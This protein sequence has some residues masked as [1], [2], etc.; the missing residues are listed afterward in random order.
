MQTLN[1]VLLHLHCVLYLLYLLYLLSSLSLLSLL[2]LLSMLSLLSLLYSLHT[3][4]LRVTRMRSEARCAWLTP[5]S[6]QSFGL[7]VPLS[8]LHQVDH[9]M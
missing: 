3:D 6:L 9:H 4:I 1:G 5:T 8:A 2:S 7:I